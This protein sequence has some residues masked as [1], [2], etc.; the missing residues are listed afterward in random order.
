MSNFGSGQP[1]DMRGNWAGFSLLLKTM[2]M[3]PSIA[4]QKSTRMDCPVSKHG[5]LR[6]INL[7]KDQMT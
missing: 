3:V 5:K 2:R 6:K 1:L 7:K 4:R